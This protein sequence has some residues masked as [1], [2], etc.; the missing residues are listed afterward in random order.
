[1]E[2]IYRSKWITAPCETEK[3]V[4]KYSKT[5]DVSGDV[6]A[7]W[8]YSSAIG[9]YTAEING[10]KADVYPLAPGW[11]LYTKRVQYQKSDI[12]SLITQGENLVSVS[13]GRGFLCQDIFHDRDPK[14]CLEGLAPQSTA[15]I[16]ALSI[17]YADGKKD[18][19][20]TDGSW[21]VCE[22]KNRCA[23]MYD[24]DIFD[25][26]FEPTEFFRAK[27][28]GARTETLIPQE[29]EKI[30]AHEMFAV[31]EVI[32]T[33]AG[34]TVLDFGQNLTGFVEFTVTGKRGAR[35]SISHGETLD[36]NGNFYN[37][38]YRS[39]KAE[40]IFICDGK[41]HTFKPEYT[42]YGFRYIRI[43]EWA[44][45]VLPENFKAT[46]LYSDI[47]RRGRFECSDERLNQLYHNIIWGQKGNFLDV[48]TDCPQRDERMGWTGDAQVFSNCAAV[49]YDVRKFFGKWL[50]DMRLC[51]KEDGGIPA[52]VPSHWSTTSAAWSDACVIIPY[53]LYVQYGDKKVIEDNYD[54]MRRWIEYMR[55]DFDVYTGDDKF[56][57]GDWLAMER[58]DTCKGL[59]PKEFIA[60]AYA[61]HSTEL[62]ISLSKAIGKD[63]KEYE[64][65]LGVCLDK[66]KREFSDEDEYEKTHSEEKS[67]KTQTYY[68]LMLEFKLC[69]GT[70]RAKIAEKLVNLIKAN[71]YRLTTGF[72][73][74]PYLLYA[75]S[76]NGYVKE[77]YS[78][79]L[80]EKCPSWL[81]SV[82][83]GATTMWEHW[84]GIK[85]N[86]EMWDKRM[87]SF[88]HYA[89]GAVGEW[90][91][92][93]TAGI[94]PVEA[95]YKTVLFCPETDER[96]SFVK[97]SIDTEYGTIRSEWKTENGKTEYIFTVPENVNATA[98][99]DNKTIA[100][101]SGE[102]RIVR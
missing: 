65:F 15:V 92:S 40:T 85:E 82:K 72:V 35:C 9:V 98:M 94:N 45:E 73:G 42:F 23:D 63:A 17:E 41:P 56:H 59:T 44:E 78:V 74:T 69:D 4:W 57:Y 58:P 11:T 49:N 6:S 67:L 31:K 37:E 2:T 102:N 33:P 20:Y 70:E 60:A 50:A 97:A 86:G 54:M 47:T 12:S 95:G 18:V 25:A 99:I 32:K 30:A 26:T 88:N 53:N 61:A 21:S 66:I 7:A 81:Y 101:K 52:V 71:G 16:A 34:E 75:L 83:K 90:M 14:V 27:A 13:V 51:Q 77:A 48:P 87:N 80:G 89:Y 62:F 3:K 76:H 38:N 64:E 22:T 84:D 68:A 8:L 19:I 1:M 46:A 29:G 91:Y 36:K 39:A 93:V 28:L 55:N 79:L 5:F 24:G 100:L 96:I 43:N 10:A